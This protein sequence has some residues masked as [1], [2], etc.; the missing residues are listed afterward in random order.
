M[1]AFLASFTSD[2]R[3]R[4]HSYDLSFPTVL[5]RVSLDTFRVDLNN[6][7]IRA[8]A[9]LPELSS[10]YKGTHADDC[11][12]IHDGCAA[13]AE[14]AT[15]MLWKRLQTVAELELGPEAL[16]LY[17]NRPSLSS[18]FELPSGV[19]VIIN[20][21]GRL[22]VADNLPPTRVVHI[23]NG[24]NMNNFGLATVMTEAQFQK[25]CSFLEVHW[26]AI[27]KN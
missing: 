18:D 16:V 6:I 11:K 10:F 13:V 5:A 7:L 25:G 21:F 22:T 17:P 15:V 2:S 24:Q 14:L 3:L 12:A 19:V 4:V 9:T 27:H 8:F 23:H 1:D 20:S 26:S